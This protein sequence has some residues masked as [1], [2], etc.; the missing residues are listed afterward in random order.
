M[1]PDSDS[2]WVR[3][4]RWL[5][6]SFLLRGAGVLDIQHDRVAIGNGGNTLY[7]VLAE[8]MSIGLC[9]GK[10]SAEFRDE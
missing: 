1:T 7:T 6:S 9:M 10:A 5:G 2:E 3:R 8:V 4:R